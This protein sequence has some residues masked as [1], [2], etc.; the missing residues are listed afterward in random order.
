MVGLYHFKHIQS[1]VTTCTIRCLNLPT[2]PP[3]GDTVSLQE[4]ICRIMTAA[5]P[6][7]YIT[8]SKVG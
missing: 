4:T 2:P 3:M 1:F 8:V 6:P 5:N 7:R